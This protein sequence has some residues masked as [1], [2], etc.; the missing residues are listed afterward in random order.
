M[1]SPNFER[2]SKAN[3][4]N[5]EQSWQ[6]RQKRSSHNLFDEPAIPKGNLVKVGHFTQQIYFLKIL[7]HGMLNNFRK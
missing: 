5:Q 3:D 7:L 1:D 4:F 2:E 6:S